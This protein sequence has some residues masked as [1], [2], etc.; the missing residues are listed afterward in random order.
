VSFLLIY[1]NYLYQCG[2]GDDVG[3]ASVVNSSVFSLIWMC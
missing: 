3:K 1:T 2:Y